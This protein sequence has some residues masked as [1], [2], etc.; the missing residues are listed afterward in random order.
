MYQSSI[1]V[2]WSETISREWYIFILKNLSQWNLS[3]GY[4]NL[5]INSDN[6]YSTSSA[7][8][9]D[10]F[11]KDL[12]GKRISSFVMPLDGDFNHKSGAHKCK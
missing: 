3:H 4:S 12:M 2:F 10:N 1:L 11:L 6:Y 5:H 9:K 7:E 8:I